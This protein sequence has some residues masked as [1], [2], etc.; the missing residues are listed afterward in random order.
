MPCSLSIMST[1]R[2]EEYRFDNSGAM[3]FILND[4]EKFDLYVC[5]LQVTAIGK[6]QKE[7]SS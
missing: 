3:I 1:C 4:L 2:T 5:V 7:A 6:I